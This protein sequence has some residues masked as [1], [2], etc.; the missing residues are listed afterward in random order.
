MKTSAT[1]KLIKVLIKLNDNVYDIRSNAEVPQE[2]KESAKPHAITEFFDRS[3][4][5]E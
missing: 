5:F 4:Y 3:K 1:V 2:N